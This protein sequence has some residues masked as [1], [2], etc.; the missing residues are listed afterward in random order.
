MPYLLCRTTLTFTGVHAMRRRPFISFSA[1]GFA[2]ATVAASNAGAQSRSQIVICRDGTQTST[3]DARA[4]YGHRG[5]DEQATNRAR[6]DNRRASNERGNYDPRYDNRDNRNNDPRYDNRDNRDN[7]NYD[8]RYDDRN[9]NRG[10]YNNGYGSRN[11]VYEW[12]GRV[13]DEVQFQ[14]RGDRAVER[15]VGRNERREG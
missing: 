12:Q 1:L 5:V 15:L 11:A 6:Y 8:P 4:C 7:R 13:D 3:N 2:I 14:I 10:G 9:N